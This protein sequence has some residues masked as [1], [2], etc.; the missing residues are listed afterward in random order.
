MSLF[1]TGVR[2]L[3]D[4]Y[5]D[6]KAKERRDYGD[7]WSASSAGYCMRKNIFERIGLPYTTVD[8]RKQRVFEAGHTFHEFIQRITTNAGVSI[9]QEIEVIDDERMIKGHF[10]DIVRTSDRTILYDYKSQNSRAFT[11]QKEK[12]IS[13]FHAKQLGTY[14]YITGEILSGNKKTK[15][16]DKENGKYIVDVSEKLR[17]LLPGGLDEG[18]ILKISKDDLRMAE[19]Q[20]RWNEIEKDK[21]LAYWDE[22]NRWWVRF[23][24][25]GELPPCTCADHDGGFMASEKYNPFF[26]NG[27]P[28]SE[29]WLELNKVK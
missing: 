21:V 22:L 17:K 2:P 13:Y 20:L 6:E 27:S 9:A 12:P 4:A 5:L 10:D 3:V 23:N 19:V 1:E 15:A 16:F 24:A 18:R 26:Y 8:S 28:C 11:W 29:A 14:F 7:Y 25:T